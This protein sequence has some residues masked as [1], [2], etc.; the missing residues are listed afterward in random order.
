MGQKGADGPAASGGHRGLDQAWSSGV[1][2]EWVLKLGSP[3]FREAQARKAS[4][5]QLEQR[6]H[7]EVERLAREFPE[8]TG[9]AERNAKA[10]KSYLTLLLDEDFRLR[11]RQL[12]RLREALTAAKQE[13]KP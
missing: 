2:P 3:A 6:C 9:I 4:D 10:G 12:A 13:A 8:L 7:L 1:P 5:R 11:V